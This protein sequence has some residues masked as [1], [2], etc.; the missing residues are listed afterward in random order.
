MPYLSP[1]SWFTSRNKYTKGKYYMNRKWMKATGTRG[2]INPYK[3][4]N[5]IRKL[6]TGQLGKEWKTHDV[7]FATTVDN[8]G[9]TASMIP[10]TAIAQGDQSIDRE[11]LDVRVQSLKIDGYVTTSASTPTT[12]LRMIIFSD[13]QQHGVKPT[14]TELLETASVIGLKEHEAKGRFNI[15]LDKKML[16]NHYVSGHTSVHKLS[17]YKK[18]KNGRKVSYLGTGTTSSNLGKG[19]LYI[20]MISDQAT[21]TPTVTWNAR[22]KFTD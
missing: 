19:Q 21:Y 16:Y 11:G 20:L 10:M 22:L 6:K 7:A 5:Q 14:V 15:L 13:T 9:G 4:A 2:P 18:F 3:M 12:I 8:T 17:Y 1:R